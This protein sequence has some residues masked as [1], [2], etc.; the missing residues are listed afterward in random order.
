MC[1]CGIGYV[2]ITTQVLHQQ[3]RQ[4]ELQLPP[5]GPA[6]LQVGKHYLTNMQPIPLHATLF[7][8]ALTIY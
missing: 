3:D 1:L 6:L 5:D 7:S 8:G 2:W 4:V